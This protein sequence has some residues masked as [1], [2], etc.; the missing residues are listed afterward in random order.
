MTL[1][2]SPF[3]DR[4]MSKHRHNG[5]AA[6]AAGGIPGIF[7][8]H[9]GVTAHPQLAVPALSELQV[10]IAQLKAPARPAAA[11]APL[12][13]LLAVVLDKSGSMRLGC[14]QTMKGYNEQLATARANAAQ[15]G[16]RTFQVTFNET[17]QLLASDVAAEKIVPLSDET[18][19]PDGGT[20]LYDT[21]VATIKHLLSHPLAQDDNTSIF[22]TLTTDGDDTSS[23]VWK[24]KEMA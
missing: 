11:G 12:Q 19:S 2:T 6:Q 16:C 4:I 13:T 23:T 17:N 18:Y 20:A 14:A 8:P 24:T 9:G 1:N 22:L 3:F 5:G 7:F 10:L 21:V 15:I